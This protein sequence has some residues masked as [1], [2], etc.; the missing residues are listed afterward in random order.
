MNVCMYGWMDGCVLC[1]YVCVIRTP[2]QTV[3]MYLK[4]NFELNILVSYYDLYVNCF[5]HFNH[6]D[7]MKLYAKKLDKFDRCNFFG[8]QQKLYR[9]FSHMMQ[10]RTISVAF[11]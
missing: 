6:C 2:L 10:L 4:F 3:C 7:K 1:V 5:G 8:M 11:N 9:K